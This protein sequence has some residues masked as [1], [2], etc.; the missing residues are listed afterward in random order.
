VI[1]G[2]IIKTRILI[3]GS[4]GMLGQRLTESFTSSGNFELLSVSIED[5]SAIPGIDYKKLDIIQKHKVKD[6]ILDFF[7]DFIINAAAFTNV[8]KSETE[9]ETAW[10]INVNGVENI[11]FYSW[12]IDAHLI[13][14]STDYIFDGKSGP[15]SENDKPD[16]VGYYGRTKLASE[17]SIHISGT[18][19]TIMRTNIL[20]GP[21]KYGRP[22]FVKWV[23][24]SLRD[25]KVIR[26]VTDQIG[27]P[28]YIDDLVASINKIIEL[29]KEGVYNIGGREMISRYDFTLRIA[30]YFGLDKS[31]I[32][33][34]ITK[35]LNQ[36]APRPLKSGLITLKA[37]TELEYKP[38]TIEETFELMKKELSL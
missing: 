7:P 16:P 2:D 18:K 22:D 3:V 38:H 4:N 37:E 13:H 24:N 26:I 30:D 14:I 19:N 1:N 29:K 34:I 35:D 28:T 17:N 6:V 32:E 10:K 25:N 31:L 27:N 5:E 12:T 21:A 23:V 15:Y 9:K 11:A 20:Y 33:K 8:D 36:P